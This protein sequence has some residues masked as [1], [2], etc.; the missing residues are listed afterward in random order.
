[1]S[2]FKFPNKILLDARLSYT[3]KKVCAVIYATQW[4]RHMQTVKQLCQ[5]AHL[6]ED[7]VYAALATLEE[8]GYIQRLKNFHYNQSLGRVVWGRNSYICCVP[9]NN[10]FTFI[11]YRYFKL[12]IS[13]GAYVL[14]LFLKYTAGNKRR[15]YPSYN[16]IHLALCMSKSWIQQCLIHLGSLNILKIENCVK[17]NHSFACNSYFLVAVPSVPQ[18][19]AQSL[20]LVSLLYHKAL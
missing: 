11:E 17:E 19:T 1:M 4:M 18:K 3:A 9:V 13:A 20:P 8:Y 6:S 12:D 7:T 15:A 14:L 10:G 5:K 16:A 2:R